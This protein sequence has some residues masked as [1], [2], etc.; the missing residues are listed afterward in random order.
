MLGFFEKILRITLLSLLL[1]L[2][3]S[4]FINCKESPK[5]D[6]KNSKP[7]E[8]II[9]VNKSDN[10]SEYIIWYYSSKKKSKEYEDLKIYISNDSIK[11]MNSDKLLCKG[12]IVKEKQTFTDYFKSKKNGIDI[13]EKLKI[14]Y[15]LNI[16]NSLLAIMNAYGDISD[17]G[18]SFPFNDMFIIDNHLFFYDK[19]YYCFTTNNHLK[20]ETQSDVESLIKNS[21]YTLPYNKKIDLDNVKYEKID[22]NSIEGLE[23]FSCEDKQVRY[24]SLPSK[25]NINL[26]LV[27]QDCADFPYSFQLLTIKNNKIIS[28]LYVEGEWFE[29]E[30]FE[31]KEITSFVIDENYLITV[32]T[33]SIK[34]GKTSL[35]EK[36]NYE[37]S[38]EGLLKK[39]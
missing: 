4:V 33:N 9:N 3:S 34:K 13:T 29:P 19:E 28:N 11:I 20:Y 30:N 35:K 25:T 39:I 2:V 15:K 7:Q 21:S 23:N 18:C 6:E 24:L 32:S 26:I 16:E 31:D 27:P 5:V 36:Y 10:N 17:K 38:N 37:I 14:D 8:K 22:V 1:L 12:E